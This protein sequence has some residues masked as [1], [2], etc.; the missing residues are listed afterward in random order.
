VTASTHTTVRIVLG[1]FAHNCDNFDELRLSGADG[2]H[3]RADPAVV[4]DKVPSARCS[5]V[6]AN[7]RRLPRG[8]AAQEP[9]EGDPVVELHG[10]LSGVARVAETKW[11]LVVDSTRPG[12][13]PFEE[14]CPAISSTRA[15]SR[16]EQQAPR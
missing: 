12:R 16:P 14:A 2:E 4:E 5:R 3:P 9:R 1:A 13:P 15:T 6:E 11:L 10:L 8:V 7:F